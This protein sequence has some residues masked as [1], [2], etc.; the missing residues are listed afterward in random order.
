MQIDTTIPEF[1]IIVSNEPVNQDIKSD[2]AVFEAPVEDVEIIADTNDELVEPTAVETPFVERNYSD[3]A[4]PAAITV[5]E[6]LLEK[7]YVDESEEF[8][9][10]WDKLDSSLEYLPQKVLNSLVANTSDVSKDVIRFVF[11]SDNITADE[12]LNFV[13]VNYEESQVQNTEIETMDEARAYLERLYAERGVKPIVAQASISALEEG[14]LLMEE[15][16]EEYEKTLANQKPKTEAL[17]QA[18]EQESMAEVERK[19]KF[20]NDII[21]ELNNTGWKPNKIEEVKTRIAKNEVN[22][23]LTEIFKSPKALVKMVDFIGYFKNGDINYET[24]INTVETP[25]GKDMKSKFE[26]AIN[27]PTLSTKSNF[28]NLKPASGELVPVF[29]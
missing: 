4:D 13:K 16:K 26:S 9:G 3:N 21:T 6:Q 7:G 17:I 8:D 1:E 11:S 20:T 24:F 27:S 23:I 12:I 19:S 10:T 28:K 2:D 25:K 14:D 15:A 29:D 18:K 22:T 5:Y